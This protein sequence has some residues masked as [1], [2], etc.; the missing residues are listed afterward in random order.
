MRSIKVVKVAKPRTPW[1]VAIPASTTGSKR[2]RRYF[3]EREAA[4]AYV[5]ALKQQGFLS[6][7]GQGL[8]HPS[9]TVTLGECAALWIAAMSRPA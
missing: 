4:L 7:E 3:K 5:I 8:R 2:V 9:S 1:L 6:A